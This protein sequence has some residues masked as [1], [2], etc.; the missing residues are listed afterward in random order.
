MESRSLS[1]KSNVGFGI[2]YY[3][4]S[5]ENNTAT[6]IN[7]ESKQKTPIITSLSVPFR[8]GAIMVSY[9]LFHKIT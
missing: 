3:S 4:Y 9:Y 2:Q 8:I 7:I 5:F 6:N 1:C